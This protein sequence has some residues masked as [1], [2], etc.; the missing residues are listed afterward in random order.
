MSQIRLLS[1]GHTLKHNRYFWYGEVEADHV[2]ISG[3]N[4]A[5]QKSATSYKVNEN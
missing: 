4:L 2:V 5:L 3:Y 1:F